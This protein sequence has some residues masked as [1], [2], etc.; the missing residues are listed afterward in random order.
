MALDIKKAELQT[1]SE[2][3]AKAEAVKFRSP[4]V[5]AGSLVRSSLSS[6][7]P[8]WVKGLDYPAQYVVRHTRSMSQHT[9]HKEIV[10]FDLP[11]HLTGNVETLK[12]TKTCE[13]ATTTF[14]LASVIKV[15]CYYNYIYIYTAMESLMLVTADGWRG[16][17]S[18]TAL[19]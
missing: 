14:K 6:E 18:P 2:K 10:E 19:W 8:I 16:F 17:S 4:L 9:P 5:T 12:A 15:R 13:G 1:L 11:E 7:E 3:L